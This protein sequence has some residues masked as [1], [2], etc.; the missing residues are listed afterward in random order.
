MSVIYESINITNLK[1]LFEKLL[2]IFVVFLGETFSKITF[3]LYIL[4]YKY[5]V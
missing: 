4:Y 1:R 3:S 2:H 5:I